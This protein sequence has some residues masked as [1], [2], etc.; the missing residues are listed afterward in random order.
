MRSRSAVARLARNVLVG[1]L[2][3][4]FFITVNIIKILPLTP[5]QN[6]RLQ[7]KIF[8]FMVDVCNNKLFYRAKMCDQNQIGDLQKSTSFLSQSVSKNVLL[9]QLYSKFMILISVL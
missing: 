6:V 5:R 7:K 1:D 9:T 3:E 8:H 4:D 2:K